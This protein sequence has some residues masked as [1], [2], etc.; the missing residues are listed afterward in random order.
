[1]STSTAWRETDSAQHPAWRQVFN[2]DWAGPDPDSS[3]PV[4]GARA[5]HRWYLLE[6]SEAKVFRGVPFR[7]RGRL[8]EWCSVCRTFE[9][10]PDGH[11]PE[12]WIPP[13]GVAPE[14]LRHDPG[15]IE[16]AR[17]AGSRG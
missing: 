14:A 1:M 17:T 7:G 8:W 9:H 12:W 11:V 2:E 10:Y 3:C 15:P 13:Y 5:L 6:D 16:E 4:C